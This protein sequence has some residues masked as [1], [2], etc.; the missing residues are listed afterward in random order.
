MRSSSRTPDCRCSASAE[1]RT[2]L[3]TNWVVSVVSAAVGPTTCTVMIGF[4]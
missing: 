2:W 1:S 3:M 4:G